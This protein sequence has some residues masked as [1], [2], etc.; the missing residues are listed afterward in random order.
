MEH[1]SVASFARF[2]LQLLS[3]GA[4]AELLEGAQR[5]GLEEIEHARVAYSAASVLGGSAVGPDSLTEALAPMASS[6]ADIVRALVEEACVGE[7]LGAAEAALAAAAAAAPLRGDLER[8]AE[9]EQRHAELGWRALAWMLRRDPGLTS[10]AR[11]AFSDAARLERFPAPNR[12]GMTELGIP[13]GAQVEGSR[14]ATLREVVW[15]C[16]RA[17]LG[18]SVV[19]AAARPS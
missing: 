8:I 7:T 10:V 14:A 6:P 4:P 18:A 5:A 11:K 16:A 19:A 1:A 13:S 2:A 9:D 17:L 15:P 12:H 3:L